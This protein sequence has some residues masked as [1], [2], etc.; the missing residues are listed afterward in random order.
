[1]SDYFFKK[2]MGELERN[3]AADEATFVYHVCMHNQS[4]RSMDCTS[5]I[6]RRLCGKK[7]TCGQNKTHA[8]IVN[9]L[10]PYAMAIFRNELEKANYVS[11]VIDSS[12]HGALKIVPVLV[13]YFIPEEVMNTMVLEFLDLPCE[14]GET[15]D[16]LTEYVWRL[17]IKWNI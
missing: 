16:H 14:T 2:L 8:T 1:V 17:V 6:I 3:L 11:I 4:F 13:R 7:F 12:T 15:A 10:A 9:V 5:K